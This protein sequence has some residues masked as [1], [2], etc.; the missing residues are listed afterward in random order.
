MAPHS[1]QP[2]FTFLNLTWKALEDLDLLTFP[3]SPSDTPGC[4]PTG[5]LRLW[6]SNLLTPRACW[7]FL[8][9]H[10]P[11]HPLHASLLLIS[12]ADSRQPL[13]GSASLGTLS[14]SSIPQAELCQHVLVFYDTVIKQ[15]KEAHQKEER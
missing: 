9:L 11:P 13:N 10:T 14:S 15:Q 12:F 8:T 7:E 6:R 2:E 3:V 4:T 5:L 1:L